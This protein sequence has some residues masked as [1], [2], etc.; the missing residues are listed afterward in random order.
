MV[1]KPITVFAKWQVKD[2][3]LDKVLN[4]FTELVDKTRQEEGNLFYTIHQSNIEPN[5]LMLYEAYI[6]EAAVAAHRASEH[7]QTIALGQII[8]VLQNREVIL[9]TQLF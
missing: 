3:E 6:D 5:T 8:P 1:Q 7:F 2:G 9:A 4:L